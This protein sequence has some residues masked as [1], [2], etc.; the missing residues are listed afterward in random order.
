MQP[1][2]WHY[3]G[4]EDF[5]YLDNDTHRLEVMEQI[6]GKW[7]FTISEGEY[8]V[9]EAEDGFQ[10]AKE[11]MNEAISTERKLLHKE[12]ERIKQCLD[13]TYVALPCVG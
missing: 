12:I 10:T 11:A 2:F 3:D 4:D 9:L 13:N 5:Y 7:C 6:G 1:L 8:E